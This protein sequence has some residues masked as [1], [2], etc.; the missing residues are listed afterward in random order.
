MPATSKERLEVALQVEPVKWGV[1]STA[2]IGLNKVIPAMAG[3]SISQVTAIASR[4]LETAARAADRLGI[5]KVHGSYRDL[6]EDP[7]IEAV[8]IPLPNHLHLEWAKA[9]AATGKHVLCEKPLALTS[10]NAREIV[11][12]CAD[13]GVLLMEAF[14]YR[15]HPMWRRVE[16][17]ID[18]GAVGEVR[19]VRTM[20]SYFNDDPDNIRNIPE[21]GGGALYDIG[22]YA[23]NVSRM[24][25]RSE[26]TSVKGIVLR[27][28]QLG[29]DILTSALMDFDG[30]HASFTCSTQLES[31]QRV[32]IHGTV[33][34]IVV[35]IPFNIP[36]DRPTRVLQIAGGDPPVSPGVEVHEIP[37]ADPYAVQAD[38]FSE[39]IRTGSPVPTPPEDAVANLEVIEQ[40]FADA[41][42]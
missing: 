13:A 21:V 20:F 31:D 24:I 9:A 32:E 23:I 36:P 8:Y 22:C 29:T 30:R 35:E 38:A 39:A 37:A 25:F 14:M 11:Q 34:R 6:L 26:P 3:A 12:A 5:D 18:S 40:I 15:L 19:S 27:D 2:N 16:E 4:S 42:G 10:D 1:L 17:I 28:E 7:D 41:E 33:G